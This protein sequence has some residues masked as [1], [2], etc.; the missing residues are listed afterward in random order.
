MANDTLTLN[1]LIEGDTKLF[2]VNC[3]RDYTVFFLRTVIWE[4]R[5]N[6]FLRG[7]DAMDLVLWKVSSV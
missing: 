5:K 7:A 3:P 1:C 4:E 2:E 6:D